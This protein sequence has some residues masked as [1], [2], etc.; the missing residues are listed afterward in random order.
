LDPHGLN[1]HAGAFLDYL[2]AAGKL[3]LDLAPNLLGHAYALYGRTARQIAGDA[4]LLIGDAAGVAYAQSG[5]GIRP[6]IESGLLA[7]KV[8]LTA[9]GCYS[10]ERL[11][12]YR[13]LL[14]ERFGDAE[15]HWLTRLGRRIPSGFVSLIGRR[16]MATEWFSREVVLNRW[17]LRQHETA[18]SFT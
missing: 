11:E 8:V 16:L 15:S 12:S 1:R 7:A 18:L 17:F 14:V 3:S 13:D 4:V 10:R 6:A 5:E 2:K 9:Q